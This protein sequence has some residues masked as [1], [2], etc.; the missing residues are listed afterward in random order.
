M[1]FALLLTILIFTSPGAVGAETAWLRFGA[2]HPPATN[3]APTCEA[4]DPST[5]PPPIKTTE[6]NGE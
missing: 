4:P 5:C 1:K 6:G 2:T 3:P